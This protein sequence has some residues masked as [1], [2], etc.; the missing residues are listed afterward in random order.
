MWESY[1]WGREWY[2]YWKYIVME[3]SCNFSNF[4][5]RGRKLFGSRPLSLSIVKKRKIIIKK[6]KKKKKTSSCIEVQSPTNFL[7]TY[8]VLLN[9]SS[10]SVC[11]RIF[12]DC[13]REATASLTYV[14]KV[15][16]FCYRSW[17]SL[18]S[19]I[20]WRTRSTSIDL[21]PNAHHITYC[22]G[23]LRELFVVILCAMCNY[24]IHRI[25]NE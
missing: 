9:W 21:N 23:R 17:H 15:A 18:T 22:L 8:S 6:G 13:W 5:R 14:L 25:E 11:L 19:C 24:A 16:T 1:I 2:N 7:F 20:I 12:F 3:E 10:S 4:K